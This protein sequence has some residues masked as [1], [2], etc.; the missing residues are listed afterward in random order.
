MTLGYN[1]ASNHLTADGQIDRDADSAH[2]AYDLDACTD[3]GSDISG[4]GYDGLCRECAEKVVTAIHEMQSAQ[5]PRLVDPA[6]LP[7][8]PAC[9]VLRTAGGLEYNQFTGSKFVA[10]RDVREVAADI[11]SDLAAARTSGLI[12]AHAVV[13]VTVPDT[14][15]TIL[16]TIE[17][18]SPDEVDNPRS[19][20]PG[21]PWTTAAAGRALHAAYAIGDSFNR[22]QVGAGAPGSTTEYLIS[23]SM[24]TV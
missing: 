18:L 10:G 22:W 7:T 20:E 21:E 16:V 5:D 13:K 2:V 12:P 17:G 11:S 14:P 3:C 9:E 6:L 23:T 24:P 1:E 19:D 15:R 4:D 8:P